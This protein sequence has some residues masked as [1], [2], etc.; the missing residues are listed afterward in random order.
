MPSVLI[1]D[2][3]PIERKLLCEYLRSHSDWRVYDA[4]N[5]EEALARVA[6]TNP[7]LVVTD[8]NMPV[9]DGLELVTAMRTHHPDIPVILITAYG[10][11][12]LA[13]EALERGAAGYVP[14]SR[15]TEKLL[16]TME[17]VLNLARA[18][19]NYARLIQC[20]ELTEFRFQLD[21]DLSLVDPL[22]DLV[23][24]MVEGLE[25]S[26]FTGRL[27]IGIALREALLNAILHGNLELAPEEVQRIR[28]AT[29]LEK[30]QA[31]VEPRR[32][33]APYKDRRVF[34]QAILTREE[35]R[36][37]VRDEGPGFDPDSVPKPTDLG[38]LD[39]DRGRGLA[40]M[41]TF[42]DEVKYN[43]KGNEVLLIKRR[44]RVPAGATS[45]QQ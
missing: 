36:F 37:L 1:V 16:Q 45:V 8:L 25:F 18:E 2:D 20:L 11:E 35:V 10:S 14:K 28:E 17:N 6:E 39:A 21:N 42:M 3:S 7:D 44:E 24:Q 32:Q 12:A 22:V 34:L 38:A 31:L 26:D 40:L 43:Q 5:G 27:R 41:R 13:V 9:M 33:Q 23:Q 19:Q 29:E 30:Q 15:L 4:A